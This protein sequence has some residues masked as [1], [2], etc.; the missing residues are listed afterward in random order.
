LMR[1][2]GPDI[3][4]AETIMAAFVKETPTPLPRRERVGSR[5]TPGRM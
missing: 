1:S 3:S 4:A 5:A 2:W